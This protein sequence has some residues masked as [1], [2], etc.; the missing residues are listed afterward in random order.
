MLGSIPNLWPETIEQK[1]CVS[2]KAILKRQ[3]MAITEKS[4]EH[5][6]GEVASKALGR[7]F[8]HTLSLTSPEVDGFQFFVVRVR[9]SLEDLYPLRVSSNPREELEVECNSEESFILTLKELLGSKRVVEVVQSL[10]KQSE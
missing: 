8:V 10:L 5:I 7:D 9:H 4:E 3:A 2:P 6:H 1:H